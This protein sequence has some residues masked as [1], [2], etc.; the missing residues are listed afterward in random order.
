ML[1]KDDMA[2]DDEMKRLALKRKDV[3]NAA[4]ETDILKQRATAKTR[5]TPAQAIQSSAGLLNI[6]EKGE[7]IDYKDGVYFCGSKSAKKHVGDIAAA[8]TTNFGYDDERGDYNICLGDH[9]AYRYEVVDVLG[10]GSF[11][12]VVR[13]ID[14]KQGTLV[15]VKIIRNKKRF[16]Q[17]AL[18]EVNILN[19]LREW[20]SPSPCYFTISK[21]LTDFYFRILTER[22]QL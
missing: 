19:K 7:I 20:V 2:A 4:K 3:E 1:D 15:A 11:G 22:M 8:G 9:L 10:K 6:Y 5:M 12:Q 18:V 17:Q 16:H 21:L 13:C 14:H